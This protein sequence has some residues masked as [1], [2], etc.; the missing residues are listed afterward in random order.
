MEHRNS[1][2]SVPSISFKSNGGPVGG[3]MGVKG[4]VGAAI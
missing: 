4:G 1:G 2:L 3:Y